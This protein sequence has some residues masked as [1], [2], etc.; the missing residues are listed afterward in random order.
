VIANRNCR[1]DGLDEYVL[2][3]DGKSASEVARGIAALRSIPR[4]RI[5]RDAQRLF[6]VGEVARRLNEALA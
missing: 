6:S 1:I 3:V 5:A 2:Y 4:A